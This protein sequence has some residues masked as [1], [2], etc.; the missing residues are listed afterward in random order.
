MKEYRLKQK[1]AK[2]VIDSDSGQR[3]WQNHFGNAQ[4]FGKAVKKAKAALPHDDL[5]KVIVLQKLLSDLKIDQNDLSRENDA[6]NNDITSGALEL[7]QIVSNFYE[8][9]EISKHSPNMK[10]VVLNGK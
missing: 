2:Q 8:S 9:D 7:Q 3:Q 10:D 4:A 6:S 1:L 5:K